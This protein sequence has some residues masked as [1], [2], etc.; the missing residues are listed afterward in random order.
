MANQYKNHVVYFGDTL[1]DLRNDTVTPETLREGY[2]AHAADGRLITGTMP[3]PS[4]SGIVVTDTPDVHGGIIKEITAVDLGETTAIAS[5]VAAGKYFFNAAGVK[6][7][8]TGQ[9][10]QPLKPYLIRPDA[11]MIKE[12]TYD[13]W[14][15]ED[16]ELTIPAYSTAAQTIDNSYDLTPTITLSYTDYHY[17]ILERFLTIPKY[18]NGSTA[19]KG[20]SILHANSALYEVYE[21]PA[22]TIVADEKTY[23]SRLVSVAVQNAYRMMYWSSTTAIS[24]YSTAAYGFVQA[25]T[26][27]GISS[28]VLTLKTPVLSARGSTTY[29]TSANWGRVEDIRRQWV[30]QVWRAPKENLN[31][32]GWGTSQQLIHI[33]ECAKS[34]NQKLT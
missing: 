16:D 32:D 26:A 27:P 4:G 23:T 18:S 11:E 20:K 1:I 22:G 3:P 25:V 2:T 6:T 28:G 9:L 8:G 17:Y 12:F 24:A 21:I 7:L 29:N 34:N 31:I 13:K 14:A 15:V 19:V 30:I 10:A 5:D 33:F